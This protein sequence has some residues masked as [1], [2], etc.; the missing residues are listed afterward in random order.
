MWDHGCTG[1]REVDYKAGLGE[2]AKKRH[3]PMTVF[4]MVARALGT[5][6]NTLLG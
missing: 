3:I 4:N 5:S 6:S 1:L 2:F